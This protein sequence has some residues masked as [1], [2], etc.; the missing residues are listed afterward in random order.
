M[1]IVSDITGSCIAYKLLLDDPA[2]SIVI[3][4]ARQACSG[5]TRPHHGQRLISLHVAAVNLPLARN[6][7]TSDDSSVNPF[8]SARL[9]TTLAEHFRSENWGCNGERLMEW[10]GSM[11]YTKDR[12]PIIGEVPDQK[13]LFICAGFNG[14][15]RSS[16]ISASFAFVLAILGVALI[17]KIAWR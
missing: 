13:G 3:L 14:H 9:R 7:Q 8:I 12:E 6:S 5:A 16:P 11:G 10:T 17:E 4:E 15:G 1:I 2:R